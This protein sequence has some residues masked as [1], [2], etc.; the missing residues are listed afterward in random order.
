MDRRSWLWRRKSLE[1]SG[2]GGETESSG[3]LSS[4]SERFSDD[5]TLSNVNT[6]SPEVTSKGDDQELDESLKTLSEKLSEALENLRAKEELVNQHAKVAEEAVSGWERAENEVSALKKQIDALTQKNSILEE[7]VGHLDGALKE[8]LRQLRQAREEQEEKIYDVV[9][10]SNEWDV[11]KSELENE[12]V[13]LRNKLESAKTEAGNPVLADALY[14]LHVSEK[15]NSI[16][17]LELAKKADKLELVAREKELSILAAE[18]AS[19]QHLESIKKV[20]RLEA[21]CRRLQA[22][23]RKA[24]GTDDYRSTAASSVY[25]ESF[26][27]SQSDSGE[28]AQVVANDSR[29]NGGF[30]SFVDPCHAHLGQCKSDISVEHGSVIPSMG[31]D[32]MHDFLEMERL[33]SLYET[34]NHSTCGDQQNCL[35]DDMEPLIN[36]VAELEDNLRKIT[37]EKESLEIALDECRTRLQSSED[38]RKQTEVELNKQLALEVEA[39]RNAEANLIQIKDLLEK[40]N[41]MKDIVSIELDNANR[42]KEK[43]ESQLESTQVELDRLKKEIEEE[44]IVYREAVEKC[45]KLEAELSRTKVE[46][47]S[48][49]SSILE[50]FRINQDK[51]MAI[52]S[53]KFFECQQTIASLGRQLNSLAALEDLLIDEEGLDVSGRC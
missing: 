37:G 6:H 13:E 4:H 9:K 52:A 34:G 53:R 21:E 22:V 27:D 24:A 36:R 51:E 2:G 16:L 47:D 29:K 31:I 35:K 23:A 7:R 11:N 45:N 49:R 18:N 43:A 14:R 12:L 17:K 19:K 8:C 1:K 32:L 5:Q 25:V 20:A 15:E 3:S 41:K 48:Q 42:R 28:R 40:A 33:A 38:Q 10:K 44:R 50:E 26:T 39:K 30:R 46:Y